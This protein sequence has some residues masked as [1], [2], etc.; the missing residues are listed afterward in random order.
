MGPDQVLHYSCSVLCYFY[1][2]TTLRLELAGLLYH[3][4]SRGDRRE[5]IYLDDEDRIGFL[6]L[7]GEV[8]HRFNWT[9]PAY[10]LMTNHYHLLVET[11]AHP[12]IL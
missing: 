9:I 1:G 2:Q 7:L 5:A 3:V 6:S 10:C 4:T 12:L 8:C 11:G